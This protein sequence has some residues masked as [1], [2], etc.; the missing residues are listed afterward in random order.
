MNFIYTDNYFLT[1][2]DLWL[3]VTKY[4]IPTIFI[5]QKWILQSNYEKHEFVG[6]GT[7]RD[8]FAFIEIPGFRPENIPSD[9]LIQSD[10]GE[11]FISLDNLIGDSTEIIREAIDNKVTI[12]DYLEKFTK[13]ITT[14]YTKKKPKLLII[15]SDSEE[16]EKPKKKNKKIIVKETSPVSSEEFILQPQK[17]SRK[18]IVVKE[19]KNKTAKKGVIKKKLLIASSSTEK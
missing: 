12:E 19:E 8:M 1:T 2:F 7:E 17:K 13:P 3:L 18:K 10:K 4:E 14:E 6:Y 9:R 16:E 15:E 5:S 11:I